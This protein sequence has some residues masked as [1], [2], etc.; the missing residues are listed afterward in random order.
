MTEKKKDKLT[1]MIRVSK[2]TLHEISMR[3]GYLEWQTGNKLTLNDTLLELCKIFDST[4]ERP[5]KSKL[6]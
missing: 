3:K 6:V 5:P 1:T 2:F 4:Y